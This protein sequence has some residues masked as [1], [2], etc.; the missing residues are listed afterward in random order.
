MGLHTHK[1]RTEEA[2]PERFNNHMCSHVHVRLF[3]FECMLNSHT[4]VRAL[5]HSQ[6]SCVELEMGGFILM[7]GLPYASVVL[8][9]PYLLEA[10]CSCLF[11]AGSNM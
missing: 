7:E 4:G 2:Q 9:P 3:G 10:D 5:G 11:C 8:K 1:L 6:G